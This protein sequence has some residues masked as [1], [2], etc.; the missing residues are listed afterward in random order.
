MPICGTRTA[1]VWWRRRC[2]RPRGWLLLARAE[3]RALEVEETAREKALRQARHD[4]Q[5]YGK[6]L[7]DAEL[8]DVTF[9]VDGASPR[10][11]RR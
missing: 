5:D 4:L 8:A 3:I 9:A 2:C 11:A 1:C 6:L 7:D 10:T